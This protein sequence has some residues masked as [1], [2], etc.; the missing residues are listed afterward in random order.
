MESV[1]TPKK[2]LPAPALTAPVVKEKTIIEAVVEKG[3]LVEPEDGW[4][5][6][7]WMNTRDYGL[8]LGIDEKTERVLL[9]LLRPVFMMKL[10]KPWRA[11]MDQKERVYFYHQGLSTA[12]MDQKER[13]YFYHQ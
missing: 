13:V 1:G 10:P 3:T 9:E 2:E 6:E 7:F 11:K 12:K 5:V 4:P 8:Y